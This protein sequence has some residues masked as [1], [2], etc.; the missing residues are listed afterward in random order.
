MIT[1]SLNHWC[2]Q[3]WATSF[4]PCSSLQPSNPLDQC[5]PKFLPHCFDVFSA[6]CN[7]VNLSGPVQVNT[8][9]L[10]RPTGWSSILPDNLDWMRYNTRKAFVLDKLYVFKKTNMKK[11]KKYLNRLRWIHCR[12]FGL[13]AKA[14]KEKQV[15]LHIGTTRAHIYQPDLPHN[16]QDSQRAQTTLLASP[17]CS[18]PALCFVPWTSCEG[19]VE[20]H[21]LCN[22]PCTTAMSSQAIVL[23]F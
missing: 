19:Q 3:C 17:G 6:F 20:T 10:W 13:V 9:I 23:G 2:W 11:W 22:A 21:I 5:T 8:S 7:F 14:L 16:H 15:K 4:P 12:L 18:G 1:E